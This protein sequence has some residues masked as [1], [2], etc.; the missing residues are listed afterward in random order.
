MSDGR[1]PGSLPGPANHQWK[2]GR[3]VTTAGYVLIK[4]PDHPAADCRGYVYEHRLV[5]ER[6]L[7]RLLA[8]GE[9]VRHRDDDPGNNDPCNLVV[10]PPLDR[11]AV[12]TCACGCGT[13]MTVLDSAGRR[14]RYVSGHNSVRR[15][16]GRRPRA[17][18]GAGLPANLRD[19]LTDLFGGL[20]AYGCGRDATTWD[21]V[22]PW[23]DGGSFKQAGNA[24]P[25]CRRCNVR[26]SGS[27]PWPWINLG[28]NSDQAL[29][30]CE[31]IDLALA[32]GVLDLPE[33][34]A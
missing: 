22:I 2:G 26:K 18:Q 5:A 34:A 19:D 25:A 28:M 11:K 33:V 12:T 20:C 30:W 4:A 31:V 29:A 14:R 6:V 13:S 10:V 7:G 27:D 1:G 9:R 8:P 21:H 24:V 23:C 32:W 3:T 17:E 15:A 16:P